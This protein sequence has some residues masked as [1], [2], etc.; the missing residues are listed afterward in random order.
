MVLNEGKAG[1]GPFYV[2]YNGNVSKQIV[3]GVQITGDEQ[4]RIFNSST[5]FNP[6]MMAM[7]THDF[8][9]EKI[10]LTRFSNDEHYFVVNK[11]FE[12]EEVSFIERPGLWNGAMFSWNTIFY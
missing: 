11:N 8:D 6:V 5:H 7:D 12:G 4:K 2:E 10:D 3:E 9:D 1:G